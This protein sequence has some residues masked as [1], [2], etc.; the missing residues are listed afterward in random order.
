MIPN[1][2]CSL[3]DAATKLHFFF[4]IKSSVGWKRTFIPMV[5]IVVLHHK[6]MKLFKPF[7]PH[8]IAWFVRRF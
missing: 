2:W 6:N 5:I 1:L 4:I 8:A 7:T 3:E